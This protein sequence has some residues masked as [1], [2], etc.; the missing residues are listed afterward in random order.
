MAL[1]SVLFHK[2]KITSNCCCRVPPVMYR[3]PMT[4]DWTLIPLLILCVSDV[5]WNWLCIIMSLPLKLRCSSCCF[6]LLDF[7]HSW[8]FC[9]SVVHISHLFII[10]FFVI[11]LAH[12]KKSSQSTVVSNSLVC[13]RHTWAEYQQ[14]HFNRECDVK[15]TRIHYVL[16]PSIELLSNLL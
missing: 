13:I 3:E 14:G 12:Q 8:E 16:F 5:C 4:D 10:S 6:S 2:K 11:I 15:M 1:N 9:V 7:S